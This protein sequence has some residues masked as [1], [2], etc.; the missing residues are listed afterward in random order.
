M[1][2]KK[3][4]EDLK[5][6]LFR[7]LRKREHVQLKALKT[8]AFR[9]VMLMDNFKYHHG[10]TG[11]YLREHVVAAAQAFYNHKGRD[12]WKTDPSLELRPVEYIKMLDNMVISG[13]SLSPLLTYFHSKVS[14]AGIPGKDKFEDI[15]LKHGKIVEGY[16]DY[17]SRP[18]H[19]QNIENFVL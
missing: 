17:Q 14:N 18:S 15:V 6:D 4:R 19:L 10:H 13:V 3:Q 5:K 2:Y 1:F 7:T 12:S 16:R 8:K 11:S 9:K